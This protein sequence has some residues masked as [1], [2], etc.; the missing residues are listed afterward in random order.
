MPSPSLLRECRSIYQVTATKTMLLRCFSFSFGKKSQKLRNK[1][2]FT[3]DG[4]LSFV[5]EMNF[6]RF[7]KFIFHSLRI[8]R[9]ASITRRVSEF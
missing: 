5:I 8:V 2:V 9:F 3:F 7:L 1:R 6:D 4:S